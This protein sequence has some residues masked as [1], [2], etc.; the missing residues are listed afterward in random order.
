MPKNKFIIFDIDGI[1]IDS[2]TGYYEVIIKAMTAKQGLQTFGM[3]IKK[4]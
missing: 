4:Y 2:V 1:L 3:Q